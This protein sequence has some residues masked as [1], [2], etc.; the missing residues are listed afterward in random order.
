MPGGGQS[1]S[2][3]GL[4]CKG[5]YAGE[6]RMELTYYDTRPKVE[7]PVSEQKESVRPQTGSPAVGGPRES[8][9]VKRRPLPSDPTGASPSPAGTPDHRGLSGPQSGPRGYPTASQQQRRSH[10]PDNQPHRR[11]LPDASS[12]GGTP[13]S[14]HHT[15]QRGSQVEYNT[16]PNPPPTHA[17]AP[18]YNED[19]FD[20]SYTAPKPYEVQPTDPPAHHSM[21][22][23]NRAVSQ[24]DFRSS[25]GHSQAPAEIPHSY[26]APVVPTQHSDPY[27]DPSY[28]VEPLRTS[29]NSERGYGQVSS[30]DL[31]QPPGLYADAQPP[32]DQYASHGHPGHSMQPTVEDEDDVPPPPP[33]HRSGA[34]TIAQHHQNQ[35]PIYHSDAPAP[36]NINRYR[37]EPSRSAYDSSPQP[38]GNNDYS[39]PP[40][41]ERRYTH[42]RAS[43]LSTSRPVSRDTMAPSALRNETSII[44][45]SLVAGYDPSRQD[46]HIGRDSNAY[47]TPPSYETPPR[48]RQHSEP[49]YRAPYYETSPQPSHMTHHQSLPMA[50]SPSY[51]PHAAPEEPRHTS[52]VHD[53]APIVKP[54]AVSP[55]NTHSPADNRASRAAVRSMPTRK[56]V[57]PR[58]PPST[59]DSGERKLSGVPFN[60][61]S[62]DVLNPS[63]AKKSPSGAEDDR[64][65]SNTEVNDKGQV[66]TFSGRVIDASDHLPLD[67]WA[68]EPEPKGPKK[69]RPARERPVLSGARDLEAAKQ[70]ER[71]Y[72]RDRMERERIRNAV[73]TVHGDSGSPSN[74]LVSRHH[75]TSSNGSPMNTGTTILPDHDSTPPGSGGR[76]R[77]QKRNQRPV[78][79]F[80]PSPNGSPGNIPM[81]NT[82]VLRERE[83]LGGYGSSPG[84]GSGARHSV[85]APP[86]PA[87]IPLDS[88]QNEDMTALSLELQSIDIGPGGGGRYRGTARRRYGGY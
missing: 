26:S 37:E 82:N 52:P 85:A 22:Y 62:F 65:G 21:D 23:N 66:V 59:V 51:Y 14:N 68:P 44:P 73:N 30:D 1:D 12:L 67:S 79:S 50:G 38:Y 32:Y 39:A 40:S 34:A 81:P 83:N 20:M 16:P 31:Y 17:H 75:Y 9:P 58:P 27:Y 56:S 86:I 7:K 5:K 70:R 55:G 80:V 49:D 24:E 76:N 36:L 77:L 46:S 61:D 41:S 43:P 88:H 8:T 63:I 60:P 87:K 3:H 71:D 29:R 57:S 11:P 15:P 54:R 35:S 13:V 19:A 28:H 84:Y 78:S 18:Q 64:H 45:S 25:Y 6:I 69:D 53:P 33:V 47:Q 2:W 72:R 74:S 42:P 48:A 4:N 10:H